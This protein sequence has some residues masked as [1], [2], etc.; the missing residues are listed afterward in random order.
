MVL[1]VADHQSDSVGSLFTV[2][3]NPFPYYTSPTNQKNILDKKHGLRDTG[4]GPDPKDVDTSCTGTQWN[5]CDATFK[6]RGDKQ[7]K[8]EGKKTIQVVDTILWIVIH[9]FFPNRIQQR[10][11]GREGKK[12][13]EMNFI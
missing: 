3:F 2:K 4:G 13:K 10:L 8:H 1:C 7:K 6:E 11:Q 12:K 5:L 9:F